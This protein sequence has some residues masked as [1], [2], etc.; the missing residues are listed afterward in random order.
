MGDLSSIPGLGRSPG[1]GERLPTP[2]FWPG[3]FRGLYSPWGHKELDTTERLLL[4]FFTFGQQQAQP[5]DRAGGWT[6]WLLPHQAVDQQWLWSRL[7]TTVSVGRF[8]DK[9][10]LSPTPTVPPFPD[11]SGPGMVT[12]FP[13][14]AS[15]QAVTVAFHLPFTLSS[16][17]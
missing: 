4:S 2:V 14:T 7:T 17:L 16:L 11:P 8:P 13:A 10:Q 3:E 15:S 6:G 9:L 5:A 1:E 12:W